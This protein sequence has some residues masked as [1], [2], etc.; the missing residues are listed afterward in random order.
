VVNRPLPAAPF[1]VCCMYLVVFI[2]EV[3]RDAVAAG[4]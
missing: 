1:I 3:S 2:F 4:E